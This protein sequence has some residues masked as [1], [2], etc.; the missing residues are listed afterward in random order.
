MT[1]HFFLINYQVKKDIILFFII[2]CKI[3]M[4]L[5][6]VAWSLMQPWF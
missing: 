3:E 6:E 5:G 2:H 4:Q 1:W